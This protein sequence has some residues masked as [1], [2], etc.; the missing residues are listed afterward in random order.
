MFTWTNIFKS[1][2][3]IQ[4]KKEAKTVLSSQNAEIILINNIKPEFLKEFF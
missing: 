4:L 3:V 2:N 1:I